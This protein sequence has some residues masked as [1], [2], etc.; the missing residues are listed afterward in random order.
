MLLQCCVKLI[1]HSVS[2]P[3][4]A[5]WVGSSWH[6]KYVSGW[7]YGVQGTEG[8]EQTIPPLIMLT[9]LPNSQSNANTLVPTG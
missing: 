2:K 7:G 1:P 5:R 4:L 8:H 9:A 3:S 6:M